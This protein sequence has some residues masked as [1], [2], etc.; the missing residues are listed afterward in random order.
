MR[1]TKTKHGTGVAR[2]TLVVVI[3]RPL[4]D[5]LSPDHSVLAGVSVWTTGFT[6]T[7]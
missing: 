3:D 4:G 6:I 7:L 1:S 2:A 5:A